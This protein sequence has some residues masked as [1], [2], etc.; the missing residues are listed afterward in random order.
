MSVLLASTCSMSCCSKGSVKNSRHDIWAIDAPPSANMTSCVV[1]KTSA[2]G[3]AFGTYS[4]C[5]QHPVSIK[6]A[7]KI[8]MMFL[9]IFLLVLF[10][11]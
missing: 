3:T 9:L 6:L 7:A 11:Y 10:L 8:I 1:P 2:D 5:M 4:L